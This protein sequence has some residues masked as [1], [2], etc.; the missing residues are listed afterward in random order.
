VHDLLEQRLPLYAAAAD[1]EADTKGLSP[2]E[3]AYGI[4]ESVRHFF[5]A[6]RQE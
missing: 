4:A 3:A 6:G 1:L 2:D 5:S